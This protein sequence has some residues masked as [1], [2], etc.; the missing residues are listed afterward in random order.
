MYCCPLWFNST[1]S[2]VTKLK[3]SYNSVLRRLLCI[4]I[5]YSAREM[6]VT[7]GIPSFYELLCKCVYNFSQRIRSSG[8]AIIKACLSPIIFI[9]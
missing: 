5:S 6:F 1:S 8:N 4:R 2:S 9:F 7:H 3:C